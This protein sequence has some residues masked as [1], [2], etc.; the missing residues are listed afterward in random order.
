[1]AAHFNRLT[2]FF[3]FTSVILGCAVVWLFTLRLTENRTGT[4][5][6][7]ED[8][9]FP[10]KTF[11][12]REPY[13]AVS[14]TLTADWI[15]FKNNTYSILCLPEE[16]I[17]A[18]VAQIGS[19]QISNIN[20]PTTYPVIRWTKDEVVAQSADLCARTTITFDRATETVLWVQT[21]QSN[22]NCV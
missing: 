13:V 3:A 7:D 6:G 9:V 21:P 19:K 10:L 18:D 8:I 17:V 22:G 4:R 11:H 12:S 16:C 15:A 5:Y 2:F 1:M 14:G 20:G